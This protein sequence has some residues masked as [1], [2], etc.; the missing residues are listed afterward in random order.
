MVNALL[1][2][3][4]QVQEWQSGRSRHWA[5]GRLNLALQRGP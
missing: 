4:L 2:R 3:K 5:L 1:I